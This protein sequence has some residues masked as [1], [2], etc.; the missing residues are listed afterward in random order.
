MSTPTL[1]APDSILAHHPLGVS[2][3]FMSESRGDWP[4]QVRQA[5]DVSQFAVEL[6]ALSEGELDGLANYLDSNPRLPFRYLSIHGPSK[7]RTMPEAKL[8]SSLA[9]LAD[10]AQAIVMHPDT[11]EDPENYRILGRKLVLEKHGCPQE[12][13]PNLRR[14]RSVVRSASRRRILLRHS[15]RLVA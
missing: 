6:S 8:A 9:R 4:E 15:P 11:I 1:V 10:R 14:A 3:G 12:H 7:G 5:W 2:T 13:R